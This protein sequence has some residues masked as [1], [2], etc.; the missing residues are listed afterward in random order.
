MPRSAPAATAPGRPVR[1]I[2]Q[3]WW[4][5]S[6]LDRNGYKDPQEVLP[7]GRREPGRKDNYRGIMSM[8]QADT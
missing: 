4:L 7:S 6:A 3:D 2:G 8:G 1:A 5:R